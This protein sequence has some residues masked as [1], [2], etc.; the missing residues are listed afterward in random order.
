MRFHSALRP[1]SSVREY[2]CPRKQRRFL[3]FDDCD[4]CFDAFFREVC[5][6]LFK[7]TDVLEHLVEF[8]VV[9]RQIVDFGVVV[10]GSHSL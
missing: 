8:V 9:T 2:H 7:T 10:M 6:F 3:G 5:S 4:F 1:M